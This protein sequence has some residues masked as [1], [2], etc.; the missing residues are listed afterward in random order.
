MSTNLYCDGIRRRDFLKAGAL[1]SG[2]SLAGYLRLAR[3]GQVQAAKA[4][5]AIFVNLGGGPSHLDTF[6]L[7]PAAPDEIRGEFKP[8]DTKVA[9]VQIS[10]HLPKLASH[11]DKFAVLRGVSHTLAAHELGTK[12]LN[13][14]NRPLPSLEFPGFG[15]VVSKELAGQRDLPSFVAIPNTPQRAGYL[16]VRYAALSTD[17][18]PK[19][20]KPFNVRGMTL[21]GGLTVEKVERRQ[22]LL[23]DLDTLFNGY[24]SASGLVEGLD[25]FDEQ[26]YEIISSSRA[27]QAFDVTQEKSEVAQEFGDTNFGQSCLLAVRLIESGV[28]F[29]TVNF[30]GW[31]THQ[32][33]FVKLKDKQLPEL[34]QGLAAMFKQ[35]DLRGLLSST[36]VFVTGEFGRTPKINKNAGRDHWPRAMF[37]L[38]G[39]GGIRSGQVVG[40]SDDQGMGP[41]GDGITPDQVAASFYHALGIDYEK[42]YH[43]NTGRPVMIVRQGSLIPEL[44]G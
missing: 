38:L 30:G 11:T 24:E 34:D 12:Y 36:V 2:L 32:Q 42:E 21:S 33:N 20:G 15:A 9:G 43:T 35:L 25:K 1:G 3:A 17:S 23:G 4:K 19:L 18:A 5:A 44:V 7:K 40:A 31:D 41:V 13:S 39:G 22:H 28:R 16:G 26:A 29:A 27:R 14:G 6:D 10:E 8:I 37:V